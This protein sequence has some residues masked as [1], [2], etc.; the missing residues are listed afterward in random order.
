MRTL[1]PYWPATLAVLTLVLNLLVGC[2]TAPSPPTAP[3]TTTS[4]EKPFEL[5]M[6]RLPSPT[7]ADHL[8]YLGV[9]PSDTFALADIQTKILLI[10]VFNFYCPHCQQE[11]PVVNQLYQMIENDPALNGQIKII[12]VG[13]GNTP[14]EINAFRQRY[15]IPFPLFADRS[16]VLARHLAIRHT[17]T[18]IGWG[19]HSTGRIDPFLFAPGT[20]G[21]VTTFLE[22]LVQDSGVD[23]HQG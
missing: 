15:T 20:I 16:R 11:A 13:V 4:S 10:E 2:T 19:Y 8:T 1:T 22:R 7:Q 3:P 6:L 23:L 9:P 5:S 21:D 12:G 17:P 18:F 14:Y